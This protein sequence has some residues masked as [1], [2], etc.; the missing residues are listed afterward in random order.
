MMIIGAGCFTDS[1]TKAMAETFEVIRK[2]PDKM[3]VMLNPRP[4]FE[5]PRALLAKKVQGNVLLRLH[6]D[7]AG[8]LDPDS[9]RII[10][11]S[12]QPELDSAALRGVPKLRFQPATKKGVP[13]RASFLFPVFFRAPGAP[14]LPGDTILKQYEQQQQRSTSTRP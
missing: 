4:P 6:I 13:L 3:P 1:D 12:G 11:S 2:R 5:Y 10:E 7:S 8:K 9:T 14:P